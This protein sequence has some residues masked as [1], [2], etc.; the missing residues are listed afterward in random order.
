M[1]PTRRT[2][3]SAAVMAAAA[4]ALGL[5]GCTRQIDTAGKVEFDTEL[6]VPPLAE[7]EPDAAGRKVF[8]LTV[9]HGRKQFVPEGTT[10]T[11]GF[12]GDHLGPT[13]RVNRGEEVA[14]VIRNDIDEDTTV[15]WHGMHLPAAADG[16]PHQ[17]VE[18]GG[19]WEPTWTIDQPAATLWYHPHPHGRTERH[20]Y[21]GLA[22][23][24]IVDDE[25]EQALQLPREYG[26]DD[27][28]LIVQDMQF[29]GNGVLDESNSGEAGLLGETVLVNGVR[30]PYFT[31]NTRLLRLR[32]LNASTAR[33]YNFGFTDDRP[34][35]LI[36]TDGGLL[37]APHEMKRLLMSPGER[38]EIVVEFQPDEKVVL[39]SFAPD[40]E[41]DILGD[42]NGGGDVLDILQ[43]RSAADL[44]ESAPVPERLSTIDPLNEADA[45][46]YRSFSLQGRRING[47]KMDMSRIDEVVTI[48]STEV[49]EVTNDH[50]QY[51]NFHVHDVQFQVLDVDGQPPPPELLGWKDT[52]FLPRRS[53]AR[54]IMRFTD[55]SDPTTPYMY[56]CH[57]LRHEDEG[58]MGQFLVVEPGQAPDFDGGHEHD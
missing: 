35:R 56:H 27:V 38:A 24:F 41:E 26:H 53:A 13:I 42:Q 9:Q 29:D 18:P 20:V 19:T 17:P 30:G 6:A 1:A 10:D 25:H 49:W 40:P 16:G 33:V 7:P 34:F 23:M 8:R 50:G 2:L 44:A 28:P 32:V 22:G 39:R 58:M 36:A 37:E 57:L 43:L 14:M 52:V 54:L 21:R 48:D 12:N 45:S 11:Y 51:H 5:S 55:H 46:Q 4:A 3:L 31:V 47:E 15:H